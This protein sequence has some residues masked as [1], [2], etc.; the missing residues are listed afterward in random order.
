MTGKMM[1]VK[2][3]DGE[4]DVL[5]AKRFAG[6]TSCGRNEWQNWNFD[7]NLQLYVGKLQLPA[8]LTFLIC[9][10]TVYKIL[11]DSLQVNGC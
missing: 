11:F 8:L 10:A 3:M 4:Y 7:G 2:R 1:D 5:G 9:D 6:E